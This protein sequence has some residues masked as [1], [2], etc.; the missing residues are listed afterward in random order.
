MRL[1]TKWLHFG[2]SHAKALNVMSLLHLSGQPFTYRFRLNILSR[3]FDII[4]QEY[5]NFDLNNF[6]ISSIPCQACKS[7]RFSRF[8]FAYLFIF[9]L[10]HNLSSSILSLSNN[11]ASIRKLLFFRYVFIFLYHFYVFDK[12]MNF[13]A[14]NWIIYKYSV[15][16]RRFVFD[17][18]NW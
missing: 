16:M 1:I 17:G 6:C 11:F 18:F 13:L 14:K 12:F 4:V 9:F 5:H 10:N 2:K 3:S 7:I 15:I 8:H